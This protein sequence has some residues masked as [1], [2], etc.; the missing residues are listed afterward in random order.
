MKDRKVKTTRKVDFR[1][2]FLLKTVVIKYKTIHETLLM[3]DDVMEH[4][5]NRVDFR[6]RNKKR[7]K[8]LSQKL[9]S[10]D[11]FIN[12]YELEMSSLVKLI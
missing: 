1:K 6:E 8:Y 10:H 7:D 12:N 11:E 9:N 2:S 4:V 3:V 5:D